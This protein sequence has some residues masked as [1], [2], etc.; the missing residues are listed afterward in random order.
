MDNTTPIVKYFAVVQHDSFP[1]IVV[2]LSVHPKLH[3]QKCE[4]TLRKLQFYSTSVRFSTPTDVSIAK[5]SEIRRLLSFLFCF[6]SLSEV[7]SLIFRTCVRNLSIQTA[8]STSA[9]GNDVSAF[10]DIK[11]IIGSGKM[12]AQTMAMAHNVR[13]LAVCWTILFSCRK[14]ALHMQNECQSLHCLWQI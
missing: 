11:Y 3:Q 2:L 6:S 5:S 4:S 10:S 8:H 14:S 9:I 1:N 13:S 7:K 12:S